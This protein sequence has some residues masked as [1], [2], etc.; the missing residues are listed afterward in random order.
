MR[1][2]RGKFC[3]FAEEYSLACLSVR[4]EFQTTEAWGITTKRVLATSLK[5]RK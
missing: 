4:I 3:N 1:L 5:T 2:R